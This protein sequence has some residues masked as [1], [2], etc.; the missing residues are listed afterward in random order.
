LENFISALR[1]PEIF[2]RIQK[3]LDKILY[4]V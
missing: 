4:I 1:I 3:K 2:F